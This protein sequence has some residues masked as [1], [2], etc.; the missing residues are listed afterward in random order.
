MLMEMSEGAVLQGGGNER[1]PLLRCDH[2]VIWRGASRRWT[3]DFEGDGGAG[4]A[5]NFR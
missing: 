2:E 1:Q 3:V 5:D 4:R